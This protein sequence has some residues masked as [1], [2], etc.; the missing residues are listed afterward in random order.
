MKAT[1][2]APLLLLAGIIGSARCADAMQI[3]VL[4]PD[5]TR[6]TLEVE[7]TDT[8]DQVKAKIQDHEAIPPEQQMLFYDSVL[9]EDGRTL[10]DYDIKK[11]RTLGLNLRQPI[12]AVSGAG[13]VLLAAGLLGSSVYF[14]NRP[15]PLIC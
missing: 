1:I 9:L 11:E 8:I 4:M 6:I 10:A 3:Y 2:L 7:A 5:S 13:V 12:P 15:R 14:L